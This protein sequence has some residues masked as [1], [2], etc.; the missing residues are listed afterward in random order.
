MTFEVLPGTNTFT[1]WVAGGYQ[2]KTVSV[3]AGSAPTITFTTV[4]VTVH[5]ADPVTTDLAAATVQH[6]GNSGT[7][8]SR[9]PVDQNGDVVCTFSR[10]MLIWKRGFGTVDS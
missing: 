1:A 8:D 5:I 7:Y 2:T 10:T 4:P 6:A 3:A 9:V